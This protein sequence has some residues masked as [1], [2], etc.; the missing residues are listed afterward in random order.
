MKRLWII[1]LAAIYFTMTAI[2]PSWAAPSWDMAYIG[3][4][5]PPRNVT[6]EEGEQSALPFLQGRGIKWSFVRAG[7][8]DGHFYNMTYSDEVDFSY[9]WAA[10]VVAGMPY[11]MRQGED[12]YRDKTPA[13]QMDVIARHL[14]QDI[15]AMGAEYNGD[16]PL[17][18]LNDRD[19]PRWEGTFTVTRQERGITYREAYQLVLQVSGFRVV[20]GIINSDADNEELTASLGRMI[21]SRSFYKEKDLLKSFL[22]RA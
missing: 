14:N 16:V 19:H 1:V 13:E 21:R 10:S 20:M 8:L 17:K 5:T 3:R 2:V 4:M 18:R 22:Q 12:R 15:Q 7:F 6:F 9:G 11:L